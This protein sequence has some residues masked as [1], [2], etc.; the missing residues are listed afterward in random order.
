MDR[1]APKFRV[2]GTESSGIGGSRSNIPAPSVPGCAKHP[3]LL[4]YS[5]KEVP[6]P[7]EASITLTLQTSTK[8]LSSLLQPKWPCPEPR[9]RRAPLGGTRGRLDLLQ[10]PQP[11]PPEGQ[12]SRRDPGRRERPDLTRRRKR[13]LSGLSLAPSMRIA[14]VGDDS[15]PTRATPRRREGSAPLPPLP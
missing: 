1:K 8:R 3:P 4:H 9:A 12:R 5:I 2:G 15:G 13:R 10:E 6:L 11:T 14:P 7:S